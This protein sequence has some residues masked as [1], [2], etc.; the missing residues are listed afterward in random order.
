METENKYVKTEVMIF[1][2]SGRVICSN[3]FTCGDSV[4]ELCHQYSYLG[5]LFTPSGTFTNQLI[6]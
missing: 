1:N 2:K 4:I 6:I 3:T 5:I